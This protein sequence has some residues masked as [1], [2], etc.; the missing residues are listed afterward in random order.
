MVLNF[1]NPGIQPLLADG[2]EAIQCQ[3]HLS[4]LRGN[5]PDDFKNRGV[6]GIKIG[7]VDDALV[8]KDTVAQVADAFPAG[9]EFPH[10][11]LR[12]R[13]VGECL[14]RER[15]AKTGASVGF[16][17]EAGPKSELEFGHH[18]SRRD[19]LAAG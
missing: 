8:M 15:V 5:P 14:A 7:P 18:A 3:S 1:L 11:A 2:G 13:S 10:I 4:Q 12:A 19:W 17:E 6:L 16:I 9:V